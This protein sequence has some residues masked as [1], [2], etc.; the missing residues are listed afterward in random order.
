M[1]RLDAIVV[2]ASYAGLAAA[3]QFPGRRVVVVE[4]SASI[5]R[6]RRVCLGVLPSFVEAYEARGNDL[7]LKPIRLLVEGGLA[8]QIG[9]VLVQGSRERVEIALHRPW[10]VV[11]PERLKGALLRRARETGAE[12]RTGVTVHQVNGD[13]HEVRV[14]GAGDLAARVLVGAD[15]VNSVA[16]RLL[17]PQRKI[18][19]MLFS[20]EVEFE[21]WPLPPQTLL[22]QWLGVGRVLLALPGPEHNLAA[23]LEVVGPRGIPGDLDVLLRDRI[24]RLGGGRVI[25]SREAV[26]R[27]YAPAS[28]S[29]R[30][31][32]LLAGDSIASFGI[33]GIGVALTMGAIAGRAANRFLSGS[34]YALPDYHSRW[35]RATSQAA[36]ERLSWLQPLL[37]RLDPERLDAVLRAMRGRRRGAAVEAR[38]LPARLPAML[39]RLFV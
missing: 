15:G 36:F 24:E 13:E 23:V 9:R 19:G 5:T 18:L 29:R 4:Q 3:Q 20:R 37:S 33:S 22:L 39:L 1:P 34:R 21:R 16:A 32:I 12:V 6:K 25:A 35:R 7:F 10:W 26:T 11:N 2:G 30:D 31:N 8:G 17:C 27:L 28:Y 14:R 38:E